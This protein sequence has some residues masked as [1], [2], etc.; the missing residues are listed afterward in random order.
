MKAN[1]WNGMIGLLALTLTACGGGVTPSVVS[2]SSGNQAGGGTVAVSPASVAQ[3]SA[4]EQQIL[5]DVNAA[6]AQ[7]RDCD[8]AHRYGAAGPLTWNA[9]LAGAALAHSQDMAQ[10][11]Y[12]ESDPHSGSDGSTPAQRV[13]RAGYTGWTDTGENV[14]AGYTVGGPG[15]VVAAWLASP[16]HCENIMNPRFREIGV[17]YVALKGA[18]YNGFFTQDFGSR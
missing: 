12:I 10:N 14:A 13:E 17:S 1:R 8:S 11:G 9:K 4:D 3:P 18:K 2:G 6:R 7:P 16:G 5:D 15:D